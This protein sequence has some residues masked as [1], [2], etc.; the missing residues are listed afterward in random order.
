MFRMLKGSLDLRIVLVLTAAALALSGCALQRT[1]TAWQAAGDKIKTQWAQNVSPANVHTEYP[2]PQM[3]RKDWACLN[4]LWEYA[5]VPKEQAKPDD[6]DGQILVPFPVESALSGVMQQP[7]KE[8]RLWYRRD[9]KVPSK[10][11][12]QQVLLHFGAVDWETTLWVNGKE[13]GSHKGGYDPFTFDIT[14]A[15][16]KRGRQ[17]IVLAVWDPVNSGTQPRGKQV[18][19]PGGIWYTSVTGIWQS[20]WLEPVGKTHINSIKI[21]PDVDNNCVWVTADVSGRKTNLVVHAQTFLPP[22]RTGEPAE[23]SGF[24]GRPGQ[25]L[26]ISLAGKPATKLWSPDSPYL[27]DLEVSLHE[28]KDN[29]MS[30]GVKIDSIKSYFGMRKVSLGKDE[31]GITRIMLNDKAI[32]QYGPLDQ[33]WWPDGL[34]TAS[35]DEALR[36]DIEVLKKLGCNMLRKHVKIE[37]DRLYYWCDKLG[38]LVWQD[39]P[40]GDRY[41]GRNDPDLERTEESAKQFELELKRMM[42]FLGNHPSI[43]MWVPFNEGWGQY[44]TERITKWIKDYDPSRLVNNASGWADR[45]VGD[46]HDIHSYPGPAAPPNEADR[47]AVLGEF[48]GLGLPVKG[49]TWQAEKNWGYRSFETSEELTDAYVQ[50]LSNLRLLVFKGLS[51]AVYTQTTDVEIEVNGLMTYDR[52]MIKMDAGRVAEANRKLYLPPPRVETVVATCEAEAV[53]YR[54]TTQEPGAN[55]YLADL[56]DSEWEKGAG[57]FGTKGT[58][59]AIVRTEWNSPDIWIRRTF[60][61]IDTDF[62]SLHL[63]IHHDED[64]QVYINGKLIAELSGFT[65][66]YIMVELHDKLRRALRSGKNTLAIHCR[67]TGGGQYI[68]AGIVDVIERSKK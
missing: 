22:V 26:R 14:S 18:T 20:V 51:A 56:D 1:E 8:K 3:V 31:N 61:L 60:E 63:A 43:V 35:T 5:I 28:A 55:W 36:Y 47:A 53:E 27:Y 2:R 4:G 49:H 68:D 64:A 15:L 54:F 21:E 48:G 33:G 34:Y 66:D 62:S 45:K 39:M 65:S 50:L 30:G 57:G 37:P 12:G 13:I 11:K 67:Q 44:D 17:E 6:F 42:D 59:G 38:L 16:K 9:F 46:V 58:P 29:R 52:S 32:F 23:P 25:R 41:I 40:S 7:G 19:K 10:W 24:W